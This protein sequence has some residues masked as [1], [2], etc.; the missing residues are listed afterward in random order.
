MIP[1]FIWG[2]YFFDPKDKYAKFYSK[3]FFGG[4]L[5]VFPILGLQL[6]YFHFVGAFPNLDF[7][8]SIKENV[9]NFFVIT[10]IV[11]AWVG[12]S[13]EV[14]KF[15]IVKY[16]DNKHPEITNTLDGVLKFGLLTGLGFAFSENILY[17][18]R[19]WSQAGAESLLAPFLFRST[20][21][22][23]AHLMFSGIFA[24][25]YGYAKFA[26]DFVNFKKWRGD[27]IDNN[28]YKR[29][30]RKYLLIGLLL[31]M[32]LHALFNTLLEIS[33]YFHLN[34]KTEYAQILV[35]ATILLVAGMFI[36]LSSLLKNNSG[37][38][39]F[40]QADKHVSVMKKEDI[41]VLMEYI[42]MRFSEQRYEEVIGMCERLLHRDP[43]NNVAKIFKAKS[44]DKIKKNKVKTQQTTVTNK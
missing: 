13:E 42:G 16:T 37:N 31:A 32:G 21:T 3:V 33:T 12:I 14:I 28:E 41:D 40:I 8:K 39:R 2:F 38:L 9:S 25:F 18:Y 24:Y 26:E 15:L 36:Y 29:F 11:Y 5:T 17:F 43:D 1:A 27:K 4:T 34:N 7:V 44:E 10:V 35:V 20:F 19:I 23:C 30:K 22:V 6:A